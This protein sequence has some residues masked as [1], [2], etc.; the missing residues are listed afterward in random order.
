[1]LHLYMYLDSARA[2]HCTIINSTLNLNSY[3][4][5]TVVQGTYTSNYCFALYHMHRP[6]TLQHNYRYS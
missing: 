1:M 6:L 5:I 4:L 3:N 2:I